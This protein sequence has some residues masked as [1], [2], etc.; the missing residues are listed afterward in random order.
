MPGAHACSFDD[1][2]NDGDGYR[3]PTMDLFHF[4]TSQLQRSLPD[5]DGSIGQR[6]LF[7]NFERG[8]NRHAPSQLRVDNR[9]EEVS[10]KCTVDDGSDNVL[11]PVN[12]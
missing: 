2:L 8:L 10:T 9:I 7:Q 4:G 5:L 6:S 11:N 1:G 3:V 12:A